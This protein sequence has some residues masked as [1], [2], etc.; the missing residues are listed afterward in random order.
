MSYSESAFYCSKV[1]L[2][3]YMSIVW[4]DAIR[5]NVYTLHAVFVL[6]YRL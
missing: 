1:L 4:F 5:I 6:M 2:G 3:M